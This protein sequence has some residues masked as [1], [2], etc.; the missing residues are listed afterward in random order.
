MQKLSLAVA[1]A[2][3]ASAC[4]PSQESA[5]PAPTSTSASTAASSGGT[6]AFDTEDQRVLYA[7]GVALG[8]NIGTFDL[9]EAEF[10][11]VA[12]GMRDTVTGATYKV[13]ME[14]YG[15][16]IQA[17]ANQRKTVLVEEEKVAAAEF[18]SRIAAEPGAETTATGIVIVP[19]TEGA[20][21]MPTADDTV[22]VHY[23]GTLRDGTVF[24][25][26]VERGEPATFPLTGVIPCWTE[27]VQKIRVGGKAKLLCPAELA[28]GDNGI[29]N[30]PG[31]ASLLFEVELLAIE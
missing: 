18:K 16:L 1:L 14:T 27:G 23:H 2:A 20:G 3:L 10:D 12:A 15:P 13:D 22:Q 28:Y 24:D 9:T 25:S 6:L 7:L 4:S 29:G 11:Y 17:L 19:M 21:E 31:G 30:I 8:E 5:T 26:S